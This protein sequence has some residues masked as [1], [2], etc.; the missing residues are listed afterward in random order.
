MLA[1]FIGLGALGLASAAGY[2]TMGPTSQLYGRNFVGLPKG[3]KKLALTYDDGPNDPYTESILN[4]LD[5]H[6]VKATF[7]L[8]GRYVRQRPDLV[9]RQVVLGHAIGNHTWDHPNLIFSTPHSLRS[10]L[11][12]T[13]QEI[14]DACGQKP[15]LFR[16]PFGGR[17]PGVIQT[18]SSMGMTAVMWNVT[19]YDWSATSNEKIE[20]HAARQ[21]RGGDV[22]L[23]HDGG[24]K[25]FGADRNWTVK[26]TDNLIR[27]YKDEGYEFVTVP[28]MLSEGIVHRL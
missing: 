5:I 8:I 25:F 27:R 9:R 28:E 4:V 12:K 6:D 19:C 10:Q 13:S 24:H 21:I 2:H 3:T 15:T 22:I 18:A 20:A 1:P 26:A 14:F 17:R 16:P 23:L 7:F 11:G